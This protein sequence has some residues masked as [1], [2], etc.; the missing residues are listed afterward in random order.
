MVKCK[1]KRVRMATT[2]KR[3]TCTDTVTVNRRDYAYVIEARRRDFLIQIRTATDSDC[4]KS[5]DPHRNQDED[6]ANQRG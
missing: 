2:T 3:K 4:C 1:C 5:W 6:G